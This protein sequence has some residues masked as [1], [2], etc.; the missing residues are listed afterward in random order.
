V[1]PGTTYYYMTTAVDALVTGNES[2]YSN[3]TMA[4]ILVPPQPATALTAAGG[5]SNTASVVLGWTASTS[6][7]AGYNVYRATVS[8][9]PYT[10]VNPSLVAGLGFTD[11][12]V[13]S[14]TTY[15]YRVTAVD[16]SGN[17]SVYSNEAFAAATP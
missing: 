1:Q 10:R 15:Y 7:V 6:T 12:N 9:G 3:Q 13:V 11:T 17:E 5:A 4:M 16:S 2:A 14:G 8:G